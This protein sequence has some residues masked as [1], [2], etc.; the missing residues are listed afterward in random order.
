MRPVSV[1]SERSK[2]YLENP[3]KKAI[4]ILRSDPANLDPKNQ[5]KPFNAAEII[6]LEED[7]PFNAAEIISL[8][9]DDALDGAW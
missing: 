3:A 1:K 6:S 7:E 5:P 8:E 9:E 2:Y 4:E